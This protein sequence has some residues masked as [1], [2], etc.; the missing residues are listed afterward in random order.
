M[1]SL[2]AGDLSIEL[3]EERSLSLVCNW[4]GKSNE[5][6]PGEVLNPWFDR[7]L[8]AAVGAKLPLVMH[9]EKLEHFNSSTIS[10]L[11]RLIQGA[12][13]K[14]VALTISYD[15]NV[16]WQRLSFDALRVFDKNDELLA[17]KSV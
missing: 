14:G 11:I 5:R 17:L 15:S 10:T 6:H 12:R 13:G 8:E 2:T 9:F 3:E 1:E 16:R 4:K 7:L